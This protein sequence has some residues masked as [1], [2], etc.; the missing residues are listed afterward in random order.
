MNIFDNIVWAFQIQ[1]T[2][3]IHCITMEHATLVSTIKHVAGNEDGLRLN[4]PY[5]FFILC[6]LYNQ[7][8]EVVITLT[9]FKIFRMGEAFRDFRKITQSY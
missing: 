6:I 5:P 4:P 1:I 2:F 9:D 7:R 3:A 8:V